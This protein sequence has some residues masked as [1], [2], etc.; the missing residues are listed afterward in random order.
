MKY[1]QTLSFRTKIVNY[2]FLMDIHSL[3]C[4]ENVIK[5]NEILKKKRLFKYLNKFHSY[6]QFKLFLLLLFCY[7]EMK[8]LSLS[9]S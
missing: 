4:M 9:R 3:L 6:E 5:V 2:F 8:I 7:I 1:M